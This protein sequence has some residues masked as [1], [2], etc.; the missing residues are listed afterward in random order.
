MCFHLSSLYIFSE[1]IFL[2]HL[3][4]VIRYLMTNPSASQ[5]LT[6]IKVEY[7]ALRRIKQ[8]LLVQCV[9]YICYIC[10]PVEKLTIGPLALRYFD[11]FKC[12]RRNTNCFRV[13]FLQ[14][15]MTA[16]GFLEVFWE[17]ID[18]YKAKKKSLLAKQKCFGNTTGLGFPSW[19]VS[20]AF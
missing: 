7:F 19:R 3:I 5:D 2:A 20:M 6:D 1:I 14:G 12:T 4:P 17:L 18:G 8:S 16:P 11:K 13:T 10:S 9:C 15:G